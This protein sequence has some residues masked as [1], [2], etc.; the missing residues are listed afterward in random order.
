MLWHSDK[1][2][3]TWEIRG[4]SSKRLPWPVEGEGFEGYFRKPQNGGGWTFETVQ[5]NADG[6]RFILDPPED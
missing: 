6:A 2:G 4:R 3:M 1:P 5:I